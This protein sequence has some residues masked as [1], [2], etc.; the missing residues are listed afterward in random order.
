MTDSGHNS[1]FDG[2]AERFVQRIYG[3][4]K[5]EL[6][7]R[8]LWDDMLANIP[9]LQQPQPLRVWEAG[10]G[11]G[12][13]ARLLAGAGHRVLL[14]D[15]SAEMLA[16]AERELAELRPAVDM[17]CASIETLAGELTEEF[18]LVV[19]HAV[20][21]WL[22]DPRAALRALHARLA[23]G[24]YLSLMFYNIDSLKL[25]HALHGNVK[26][27]L[28]GNF[29]G[30]PGGLTPSHPLV[31]AQ[32]YQWLEEMGLSVLSRCGIRT[33]SEYLPESPRFDSA[34]LLEL[35]QLYCRQEPFLQLARYIHVVCRRR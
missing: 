26:K 21:E 11:A 13:M 9:A 28:A 24:G 27:L 3:S 25:T 10:G 29:A 34:L 32:V 18:P 30:H 12:Q 4:A 35:E 22:A 2:R 7:L 16:L 6:R 33:I 5:G 23:P 17:R 15:I 8:M 19:C 1:S 14:S 31:P 20:L